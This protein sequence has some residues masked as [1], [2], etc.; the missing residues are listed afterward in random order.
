MKVGE[1][2]GWR[3]SKASFEIAEKSQNSYGK[4][5]IIW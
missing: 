5:K 4:L 1:S 2:G 3:V